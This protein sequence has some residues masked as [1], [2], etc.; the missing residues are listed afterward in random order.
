MIVYLTYRANIRPSQSKGVSP[1]VIDRMGIGNSLDERQETNEEC[2]KG[3]RTW[4]NVVPERQ[5]GIV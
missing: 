4:D 5:R 2:M 1:L 3:A